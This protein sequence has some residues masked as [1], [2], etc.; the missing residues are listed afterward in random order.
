MKSVYLLIGFLLLPCT[1]F[2]Q[3]A[4]APQPDS[5]KS[6]YRADYFYFQTTGAPKYLLSE[7][8]YQSI[9]SAALASGYK[10]EEIEVTITATD[11]S[12]RSVSVKKPSRSKTR[13]PKVKKFE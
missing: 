3:H 2:S 12:E 10:P 13:K 6:A 11:K 9:I 7:P 1:L 8:A 5:T 4:K